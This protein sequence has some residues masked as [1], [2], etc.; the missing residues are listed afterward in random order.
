MDK[1]LKEIEETLKNEKI[2]FSNG[3]EQDKNILGWIEALEYT[4]ALIKRS[5]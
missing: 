4:I 5:K 2:T 3:G 1:I